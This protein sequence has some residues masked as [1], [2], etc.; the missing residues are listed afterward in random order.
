ME[1]DEI[2]AVA[3]TQEQQGIL[4]AD[5]A[6]DEMPT[7]PEQTPSR[8]ICAK[9]FVHKIAIDKE[10]ARGEGSWGGCCTMK[11]GSDW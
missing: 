3:I 2:L 5:L 6:R 10:Y 11:Q 8:A 7:A 4:E 9:A 1:S